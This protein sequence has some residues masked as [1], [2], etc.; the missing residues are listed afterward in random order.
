MR[1]QMWDRAL[2]RPR[3]PETRTDMVLDVSLY[4]VMSTKDATA[5]DRPHDGDTTSITL[6]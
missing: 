2:V 1:R 4:I 3:R 6:L 5:V